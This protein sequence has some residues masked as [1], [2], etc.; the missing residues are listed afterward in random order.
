[1]KKHFFCLI[2]LLFVTILNMQ[3]Q[4]AKASNVHLYRQTVEGTTAGI[5]EKGVIKLNTQTNQ[6]SF[7]LCLFPILSND[8][9]NDAVADL[10]RKLY[11]NYKAQFPLEGIEFY[12]AENIG[13]VYTLNGE[14]TI[15]DV[16]KAYKMDFELHAS[17]RETYE[18]TNIFSYPVK[19]SFSIE[20]EPQ[21]FNFDSETNKTTQKII[22]AVENGTINQSTNSKEGG[23]ECTYFRK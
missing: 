22:A 15:N 13:Q 18:S 3:A 20:F 21:D 19:I 11:M 2:M 1:M 14:L 6:F 9:D 4:G 7:D 10:K 23:W 12:S 16:V 17:L 8:S 5:T